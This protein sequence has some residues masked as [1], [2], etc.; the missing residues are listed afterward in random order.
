MFR[1]FT[2]TIRTHFEH[3]GFGNERIIE[4]VP[5]CRTKRNKERSSNDPSEANTA[6]QS[7]M[8]WR[9]ELERE[10]VVNDGNRVDIGERGE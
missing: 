5:F 7:T 3:F 6:L 2:R 9:M 8:Q 10:S 1:Y 4:T